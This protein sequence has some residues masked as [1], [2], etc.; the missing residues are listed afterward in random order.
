MKWAAAG[1]SRSKLE[2]LGSSLGEG[3]AALPLEI[4]DAADDAAL[5]ALHRLLGVSD[6]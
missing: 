5:S 6:E 4:A 3:G 1:R 2:A